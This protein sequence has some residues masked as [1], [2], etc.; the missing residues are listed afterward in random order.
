M[1]IIYHKFLPDEAELGLW[2]IEESEEWFRERL[3]LHPEE[4]QQLNKIK[5]RRRIEWLAVR[6]L[7]HVMSQREE[8]APIFKD[9]S[10]KP[11]IIDTQHHISIS[12]SRKLAA[13]TAGLTPVGVDIQRFVE[14]IELLA[15]RVFSGGE[16]VRLS[17]TYRLEH[18]HVLWGAKECLY[19]AYGRRQLD[20][21]AHIFIPPFAFHPAGGE[22]EGLVQ[23]GGVRQVYA[24]DYEIF[25]DYFLVSA[26]L[27]A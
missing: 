22:M 5:G 1:P 19:K 12:H 21:S 11:H 18:M 16:M 4:T 24:I 13:A 8:R 26:R 9:D 7:L 3:Q 17:E 15:P 14:K 10:G 6:Q 25:G 23:K 20:F 2:R 27:Q